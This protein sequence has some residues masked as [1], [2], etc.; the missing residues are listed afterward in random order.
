MVSFRISETIYRMTLFDPSFYQKN[1]FYIR[2]CYKLYS[3]DQQKWL[4]LRFLLLARKWLDLK[5]FTTHRIHL[6]QVHQNSHSTY[7][8]LIIIFT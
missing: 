7:E 5:K 8:V 4:Q 6:N 1:H 3:S 2:A